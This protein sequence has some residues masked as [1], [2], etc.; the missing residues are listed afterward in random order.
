MDLY[1]RTEFQKRVASDFLRAVDEEY[2]S[3]V[4]G[5]LEEGIAALINYVG[6]YEAD[7]TEYEFQARTQEESDKL[8]REITEL[9][10]AYNVLDTTLQKLGT[11][12]TWRRPKKE[13]KKKVKKKP[14]QGGLTGGQRKTIRAKRAA[15]LAR[16]LA[17]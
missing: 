17:G 6:D 2:P 9:Q 14:K 4:Y 13:V 11:R 5:N 8:A 16:R 15:A 3:D 12:P 7:L 1:R 10:H